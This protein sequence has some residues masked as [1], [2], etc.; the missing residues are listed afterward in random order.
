MKTGLSVENI[1]K[2]FGTTLALKGVTFQVDKGEIVAILGPSGCGKS[3]LL[4]IIAGLERPDQGE[5]F[6]DHQPLSGVPA[7][8]RDFGLMFQDF[9]LFPHMN[10]FDNISFGIRMQRMSPIET[11]KRVMEMLVL[12]GLKGYENRDVNTLSGG[13]Q[14]R[15]ALARSLAPRPRLLMLD[16]PLG[17]LDRN[18]REKLILD[19]RQILTEIGQTAIYV[20][21]D[22]EE[23]FTLANRVIVMNAGQVEQIGEPKDIYRHPATLFVALFLGFGNL[24]PGQVVESLNGLQ[25]QTPIGEYPVET[26]LRGSV[27]VLFRPDSVS[28]DNQGEQKLTGRMLEYSFQGS[29]NRAWIDIHGTHLAFEFLSDIALPRPGEIVQISFNP[30]EAFQLFDNSNALKETR[31][32]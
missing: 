4:A 6:W 17:S 18:L 3:T 19:L 12:V 9:A 1:H 27:T 15:I 2:T 23:A 30:Q 22:Q 10:V 8:R 11:Q 5:I 14:Q 28:P 16:E 21:H 20:T 26:P 25:L 29:T 13:E 24:I 7:Y 31:L 32:S